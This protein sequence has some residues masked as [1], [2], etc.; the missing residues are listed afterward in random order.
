MN[1][2]E[3]VRESVRRLAPYS[4]AR[5]E[6]SGQAEVFL[7]ANENPFNNGLNRYPD[8][9]QWQLKEKIA[10]VKGIAL[11]NIFLGNGS[12]EVID[13]LFRA[14]CEPRLDNALI[15]PPTYGM[16]EVSAGINDVPVKKI[17]LTP[18]FQL[19]VP[20][21]LAQADER[22]K[23]LFICSPNNPTGNLFSREAIGI[24]LEN[25][26]G[27][28]VIDEAYIDFS[29]EESWLYELPNWPRLV[30]MQTLSKA[31]GLAG[32]RLGMCFA[33]KELVQIL[34]KIKPPYNVNSLTQS[35]ALSALSEA[36]AM[37]QQV[38]AI[39]QERGALST[40]LQGLAFVQRVH[41]S[42]ANFLLAKVDDANSLYGFLKDRGIIVRNRSKVQ[43]CEGC[44]RFT[45]GTP[46]ENR[47]LLATLRNWPG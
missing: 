23:L 8:A 40:A 4:C 6:F 13:L 15:C 29:D 31:W 41:P 36:A 34:N 33:S 45:V 5:D 47:Q 7:D 22:S 42:D 2:N 20:S 17:P 11:E 37:R 24:L 26:K 16:Y 18:D 35:A 39:L 38:G 32:I 25:F 21:I 19:D 27:I 1:I 3:L 12:D 43:L 30:V 14:F 44:L 28:V 46:E 10:E 9:Y